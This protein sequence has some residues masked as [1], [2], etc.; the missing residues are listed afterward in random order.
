MCS[1]GIPSLGDTTSLFFQ[2]GLLQVNSDVF[3]SLK[4][5]FCKVKLG[6]LLKFLGLNQ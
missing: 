4:M 1:K 6:F 3:S 2:D 5:E